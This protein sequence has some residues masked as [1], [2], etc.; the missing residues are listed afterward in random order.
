MRK[1]G[2]WALTLGMLAAT[3]GLTRSAAAHG[4]AQPPAAAQQPAKTYNQQMAEKIAEALRA[5]RLAAY[6]VQIEFK[7]GVATIKGQ[8]AD[9]K[10]KK[11]AHDAVAKLPGVTQVDDSRLAILPKPTLSDRMRGKPSHVVQAGHQ[12]AG[13]DN[14]VR[15]V[16][17]EEQGPATSLHEN[18][19]VANEIGAALSQASLDGYDLEIRFQNGVALLEGK[20]ATNG[21]RAQAEQIAGSVP[22]VRSVANRLQVTDE[23]QLAPQPGQPPMRGDPRMAMAQGRDPRAMMLANGVDPR[24]IPAA[25]QPAP[26]PEPGINGVPGPAVPPGAAPVPPPGGAYPGAPVP[27][28]GGAYPGAPVPPPGAYAT[29]A[30]VP[31]PGMY[32]MPYV[33]EHAWPAYAQY[34]NSAAVTYPQQYSASAWPYIG[35]FYPYPQVPL[36]W[37]DATLRWDD[38]FWNLQFRQRTDHWWWFLN[39]HNW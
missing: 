17:V 14:R 1:Y 22:G 32:T 25:Y 16:N 28:P 23:R 8:I 29:P 4:Q 27:P 9:K 5:Q 13:K 36:G 38:G 3:P 18:Q 20:V 15:Q 11:R 2:K 39:P 37:R 19:R 24:Y 30:P 10:Q 12:A 31:A 7:D 35:P 21:Q 6:E 33:P 26:P 34:P